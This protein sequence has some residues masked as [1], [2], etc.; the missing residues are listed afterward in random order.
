MKLENVHPRQ[1]TGQ[2]GFSA[3]GKLDLGNGPRPQLT[4]DQLSRYAPESTKGKKRHKRRD[5][6]S[7]ES[8]AQEKAGLANKN[9]REW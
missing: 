8:D 9:S 4:L 2:I 5:D 1:P 7:E 3:I 6:D